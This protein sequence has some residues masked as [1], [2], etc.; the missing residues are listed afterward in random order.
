LNRAWVD[1]TL[2]TS[3]GRLWFATAS[4]LFEL[5]PGGAPEAIQG[6]R[7]YGVA[8]GLSDR[9]I[10]ALCEDRDGNLWLGS[11]AGGAMRIARS[12]IRTY[13]E[14]DGLRDTRFGAL[15]ENQAGRLFAITGFG[16]DGGRKFLQGFDGKTFAAIPLCPNGISNLG[17]GSNQT[18]FEDHAGEWWVATAYGLCRFPHVARF[19]QLQHTRPKVIYSER[20]GLA[21]GFIFRVFEDHRGDIWISSTDGQSR[22]GLSRW[23]RS[24][25]SLRHF[26]R[27]PGFGDA[28][29]PTAFREDR[30]GALWIGFYDGRVARYRDNHFLFLGT[31]DVVSGS[32]DFANGGLV[33]DIFAD[34][35]GRLWIGTSRGGLIRIDDPA[36][37]H[38]HVIAYTTAQ[39]LSSNEVH[40]IT[41]DLYGRLYIGTGR[42]LD[43]LNPGGVIE[44]FTTTD[45]L[46]LGQPVAALRDRQG[47]LWFGTT[48]GLSRWLPDPP[49]RNSPPPILIRGVRVRGIPQPIYELGESAVHPFS[50]PAGQNQMQFDFVSITF[51]PAEKRRYQYMLES[52]D[53]D[54]RLTDERTVNYANLPP[55]SY[56]FLVRAVD[57]AG[58]FSPTPA[59]AS[60]TIL[61][62]YWQ[63]W[64]F[65]LLALLACG[66]LLYGAHRY[67]VSRLLELERVRM[68]IATDLHD[69]IGASLSQIA[70]VSEAL[71]QR[72]GADDR[73][74]EPLSQ[75]AMDSREMVSSMSDL[76]WAIDPRR[77]H[78]QDLVQRMRRFA[79]DLLTAR[80]M[81]FRFS[82][83]ASS[84]RLNVDQRRHIFLIFKESV[85]N[86]ARH[87]GCTEAEA[88]LTLEGD[89]LVLRV[90]D[91]GR[92]LEMQQT[93]HGNGL[94]DMR[95]RAKALGGE[96]EI[97]GCRDCGTT[98]TLRV[99]LG[100]LP[101]PG[102]QAYFHLNRW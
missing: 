45:G 84:L 31:H 68:R 3:D 32:D 30:T 90:H 39:G 74:R 61:P 83:P 72:G 76:V 10:G 56:R 19:E 69:D 6:F 1:A 18:G 17:W 65:R 71:S 91:N 53:T 23:Q 58:V 50:L 98:V 24:T 21:G 48:Q 37:D 102:W 64:W 66:S 77:D 43:R 78:L 34:H 40:C 80:N 55:G 16:G 22:N 101:G 81:E 95:A 86:V 63:R 52:A 8:N 67:N 14:T 62:P 99:P 51:R 54:W 75:I 44:H 2:E 35:A 9:T 20:D 28:M 70:A 88:G 36:L 7:G 59:T 100:R 11:S 46:A 29:P 96:I 49:Q 97:A 60:F 82:A 87:S 47:A 94:S 73:Y 92:G 85:N 42:G 13:T 12:G 15:F 89:T 41:E 93:G 33:G 79:S 25:G 5:I 4:G 26:S 27:E 38:S 57:S